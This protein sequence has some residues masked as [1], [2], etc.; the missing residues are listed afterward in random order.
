M[1][2]NFS[3]SGWRQALGCSTTDADI[4]CVLWIFWTLTGSC[5]G[6]A[7][8]QYNYAR[9]WVKLDSVREMYQMG[10]GAHPDQSTSRSDHS[11]CCVVHSDA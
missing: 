4:V 3:V 11:D 10:I 2:E 1:A 9:V 6:I 5:I 7:L 8:K